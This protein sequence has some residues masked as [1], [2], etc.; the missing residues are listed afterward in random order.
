MRCKKLLDYLLESLD[1]S[2]N[3]E[4][5]KT[6]LVPMSHPLSLYQLVGWISRHS[7]LVVHFSPRINEEIFFTLALPR[8]Y[9]KI[10]REF[11]FPTIPFVLELRTIVVINHRVLSLLT[12]CPDNQSIVWENSKEVHN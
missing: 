4:K 9:P 7:H 3:R 11:Y 12:P 10:A 5:L 2:L 1:A 6:T 8:L